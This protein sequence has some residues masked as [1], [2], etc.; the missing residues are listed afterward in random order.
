MPTPVEQLRAHLTAVYGSAQTSDVPSNYVRAWKPSTLR[1]AAW[2]RS[3]SASATS[4]SSPTATRSRSRAGHRYKAWRDALVALTGDFLTGVHI[5]P[6]IRTRRTTASP[7][8]TTR[9]STLPGA[10][11]RMCSG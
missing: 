9:P 1:H 11:G 8:S 3:E 7:W 4:S 6:F 2:R 10:T 5:L